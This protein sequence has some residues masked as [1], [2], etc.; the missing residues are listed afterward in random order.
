MAK[1]KSFLKRLLKAQEP[2][3][4][5]KRR[6]KI[7]DYIEM[8]TLSARLK[9]KHITADTGVKLKSEQ[10]KKKFLSYS[11][12]KKKLKKLSKQSS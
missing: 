3:A 11:E 7:P 8:S 9:R 6:K 12:F 4:P 5:K 2:K 10:S 1:E